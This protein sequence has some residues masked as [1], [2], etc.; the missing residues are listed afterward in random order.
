MSKKNSEIGDV[1]SRW[2]VWLIPAFLL[3][4]SVYVYPMFSVINYSFTNVS[5]GK[6]SAYSYTMDSWK[7]VFSRTELWYS[8]KITL[9][10]ALGS[11]VFQLGLGLVSA[12]LINT[13]L[14]GAGIV[15]LAMT[16]AWVVPGV[17]AGVIWQILFSSSSYGTINN[18]F[19]WIGLDRVSFLSSPFSALNCA[20]IANI[21]R[22]TG[23][24][25]IMQYAALKSIPVELYESAS[26]AGAGRMRTFF[27]I[28]LPQL[29]P[30]LLINLVLIT[31]ASINT[32]DSIYSLTGGGP[33]LSTTVLPLMTYKSVFTHLKLSVGCVYA[34][35]LLVIS[36]ALTLVYIKLLDKKE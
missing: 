13:D 20:L 24:S 3:I 33:G 14:R 16:I 6:Q 30:M 17:I 1:S 36:V 15:K 11:V 27:S 25:G 31:I 19:E 26:I 23:F 35:L 22:G 12:L 18:L 28:T 9:Y 10:F 21:W 34:V 7:E 8:L 4:G 32:Y 2:W 29:R 5:I